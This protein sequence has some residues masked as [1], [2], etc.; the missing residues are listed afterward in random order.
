MRV[1]YH[2]KYTSMSKNNPRGIAR[3]DYSGLMTLHSNLVRQEEY[4]GT[5][6]VWTGYFVNPK[7]ADRPNPQ[8]LTPLVGLDPI[9]LKDSRP[10][11]Q[12][13]AQTTIEESTGA[14]TLDVSG[15]QNVTLTFEQFDNGS[16]T[17]IGVLTGDITIYVPNTF[18]QFYANNSTTGGFTLSMQVTGFATPALSIPIPDPVTGLGPMVVNTTT[19]LQFVYF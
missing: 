8:N 12:I 2:G 11:A 13:D 9:P 18:N 17:F 19:N 1:R 15:N 3:C 6:L 10:D 7:F 5:G 16:L 4:R 14:L